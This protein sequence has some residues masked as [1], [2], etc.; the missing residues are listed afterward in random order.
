VDVFEGK[1][2]IELCIQHLHQPPPPFAERGVEVPSELEAIVL[3]C[4]EKQPERRPQTAAELRRRLEACSVTPWDGDQANAWWRQ[5]GGKLAQ[6]ETPVADQAR[7]I[8]VDESRIS[9]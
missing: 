1:S 8:R 6:D 5:Y 3:A 7:T 4:L 2:V 9:P